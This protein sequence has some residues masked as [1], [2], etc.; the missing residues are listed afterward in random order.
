MGYMLAELRRRW[1]R[2]VLTALGLAV[3]VGLVVVVGALSHGLG[4]AQDEILRPLTGLGTDLSVSRPVDVSNT[5]GTQLTPTEQ[6]QLERENASTQNALKNLGK[7]GSHFVREV[8]ASTSQLSFPAS[9]VRRIRSLDGV[10]AAVG[11]LTLSLVHVEGKVP[12][13]VPKP[14]QPVDPGTAAAGIRNLQISSSTVAGVD[15]A[16]KAL[17]AISP[18]QLRHGRWF[19]GGHD[20]IVNTGYASAHGVKLG[21][22][23]KLNKHPFTVVGTVEPPLG[24]QSADIYVRLGQLQALSGRVGR[25][26]RVYVR[27]SSGGAVSRLAGEIPQGLPGASV[28]TGADLAKRVGGSLV[29]AKN[30]TD[31]LGTALI[32]VGLLAAVAI[33]VLLTLASVAKRVRELGTLK[34]LG[35]PQRIVVRQ[36]TGEAL[37]QG[38]VGGA[39]GVAVGIGAAKLVDALGPTLQ[40][41]VSRTADTQPTGFFSFGQGSIATGS[42][43][44]ALSAPIEAKVVLLAVVLA[45]A[46]GLV[47]GAVGGLRAA[48]L[49]PAEALRHL[50]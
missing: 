21:D 25:V 43:N 32:A 17:G 46:A 1:A 11:G 23:V 26:N 10:E 5:S 30:L 48:R 24:S 13:V 2:T 37:L 29:D 47:A 36:V 28:T 8:F 6:A 44:V 7:P 33:A 3:G 22:T 27:A 42:T 39:F 40:A 34:A 20:A 45:V 9:E 50:G 38:L 16:V 31:K 18:A 15:V 41:T 35:W 49:R 12:K 4:R 19:G 14:G